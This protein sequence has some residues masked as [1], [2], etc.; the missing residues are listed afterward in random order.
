[1]GYCR[2]GSHNPTADSLR[3]PSSCGS[4]ALLLIVNRSR[5]YPGTPCRPQS[6]LEPQPSALSRTGSRPDVEIMT[7]TER[8]VAQ[9]RK[10][11]VALYARFI[12]QGTCQRHIQGARQRRAAAYRQSRPR[13]LSGGERCSSRSRS[14]CRPAGAAFGRRSGCGV[15]PQRSAGLACRRCGCRRR[16]RLLAAKHGAGRRAARRL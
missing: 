3:V 4:S 2:A 15:A 5:H 6:R 16:R 1:M 13:C 11:T 10:T 12:E 9:A 7:A 14:D 8:S